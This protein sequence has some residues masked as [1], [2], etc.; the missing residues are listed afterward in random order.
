[1]SRE[2]ERFNKRRLRTS[3]ITT[4]FSIS[5]V[6]LMIGLLALIILQARKLSDYVKENIGF[7]VIIRDGVKD[8][9]ILE[10]ENN[11][12]LEPFV[13]STRFITKE[14]AAA[15]L[16]KDL[17]EDFIGFLGYN[18]LLASIELKLNAAYANND[19]LAV[20]ERELNKEMIVQEVYYQKSLVQVVNENIRKI[21]YVLIGF[22][23]LLLII[24]VALINNTIR[25]AVYSKRLL[26]RSMQL[27]GATQH[28]IRKPFIMTGISQGLYGALIAISILTAIM[29]FAGRHVPE[30]ALLRDTR[31]FISLYTFVILSG[32]IISGAS[33]FL[34][35]R[36]Y[37]RLDSNNLY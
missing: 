23:I 9:Q 5:L 34:A 26:I 3:F 11:L 19:S 6:L 37:L 16:I 29:F 30:L 33:T 4:V 27:V 25:L 31:L 36:K 10:L 13:K 21:G 24:A 12:K 35:V 22:S 20:I 28:F 2:E 15:D 14:E 1:M 7:S 18:P 32:L 17:G 8:T